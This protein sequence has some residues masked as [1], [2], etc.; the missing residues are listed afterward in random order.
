M[1][2]VQACFDQDRLRVRTRWGVR[3]MLLAAGLAF[4]GAPAATAFEPGPAI[5]A[6]DSGLKGGQAHPHAPIEVHA[7]DARTFILREN[8]C[9]TWEAPFLYLLVG[10]R[11]ALLIDTGDLA[12]PA[13]MPLARTVLGL[14]PAQFPLTVLHSHSHLDHRAGDGQFQALAG[15]TVVPADFEH[16]RAHFRFQDWPQGRAE[17]DLGDRIVDVLPTPGHHK[18]HLVF[19]DR[20][21]AT[22]FSGDFLLPGRLLVEDWRA[23]QASALRLAA[24]LRDRPVTAILG[25]HIEKD[26]SGALFPWQSS[27]HPS[28]GPLALSKADA[29]ALPAALARFNGFY[30]ETGP[31]IIENPIHNLIALGSVVAAFLGGFGYMIFRYFRKRA[32]KRSVK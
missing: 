22:L 14:L 17:V 18:A 6:W 9:D 13:A 32:G 24:F 1:S 23:Y 16:V 20:T 3:A 11:G 12:D 15:V 25:G 30:T 5:A 4:A 27:Y 28:E 19:Y 8:L 2:T 7:L 26:Q 10:S 29:L 31:F 21:T